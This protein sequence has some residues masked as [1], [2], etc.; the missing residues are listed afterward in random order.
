MMKEIV[1]SMI[2]VIESNNYAHNQNMKMDGSGELGGKITKSLHEFTEKEILNILNK[3]NI[4]PETAYNMCAAYNTGD[5]RLADVMGVLLCIDHGMYN[6]TSMVEMVLNDNFENTAQRNFVYRFMKR[7]DII[8]FK[9]G[10]HTELK[11]PLTI[12][13]TNAPAAH[14]KSLFKMKKRLQEERLCK[15]FVN[16]LYDKIR[17]YECKTFSDVNTVTYIDSCEIECREATGDELASHNIPD[18]I[19][20]KYMIK[21]SDTSQN[22]CEMLVNNLCGYVEIDSIK[23]KN[24]KVLTILKDVYEYEEI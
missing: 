1:D 18:K 21:I 3:N 10:S 8:E 14:E 2:A 23:C 19:F 6:V 9:R 17:S 20:S 16:D 24:D 11:Q 5:N 7:H 15:E 22:V 12:N 13:A 4:S